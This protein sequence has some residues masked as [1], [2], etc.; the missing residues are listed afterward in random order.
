MRNTVFIPTPQTPG[1]E[2]SGL[3]TS[4][5]PTTPAKQ[6]RHVPSP[7]VV[8]DDHTLSDTTSIRSS[9]TLHSMSGPVS[10]PEL[11]EPGLNASIIE[12]VSAWFSDG[13]VTKSFVVGELALAYNSGHETPLRDVRVRLDNF[14]LLEKVAANPNFVKE[15]A[16]EDKKGEYDVQLTSISRPLPTVAFKYQVHINPSN[17]SAYCPVVFQPIWNLEQSQASAIIQYSVNPSFVSKDESGTITLKN[18]VLTVNLDTTPEEDPAK[19]SREVAHAT[20]AVMYPNTGAKFRRKQSAVVW[21]MPEL[22]VQSDTP[23]KFL[24]RFSTT[25]GWPHKGK[26]D[27][28]FELHTTGT[29]TTRLGISAAS[30][31]SAPSSKES[32]PFADEDAA[33]SSSAAA[34]GAAA[35]TVTD[36]QEIPTIRK[37]AAGKYVST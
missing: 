16:D 11:H 18:V 23:G 17:A 22:E 27:A 14:Q 2:L 36:W 3:Y 9:H 31:R 6:S 13:A 26:V 35:P 19:Q 8:T 20:A 5:T 34:A 32:D 37:L 15:Q 7:S 1:Q 30:D 28:K 21:K 25:G 29:G 4:S 12:T 10:H 24:V 33:Q